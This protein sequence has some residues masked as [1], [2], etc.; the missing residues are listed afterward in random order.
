MRCLWLDE[1]LRISEMVVL[2]GLAVISAGRTLLR[3]KRIWILFTWVFQMTAFFTVPPIS[4]VSADADEPLGV[5]YVAC[6][7]YL[8]LPS[9]PEH[10]DLEQPLFSGSV[11]QLLSRLHQGSR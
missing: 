2:S 3:P 6:I 1:R 11:R 5:P 4:D 7:L 9:L 8:G 10:C